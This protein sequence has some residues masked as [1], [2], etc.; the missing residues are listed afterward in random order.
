MSIAPR[1]SGD[2]ATADHIHR[3]P[4]KMA[5]GLAEHFFDEIAGKHLGHFE[6]D[7]LRRF[8]DPFCGSGTTLLVARSRGLPASGSDILDSSVLL[9]RAK[10]NRLGTSSLNALEAE[11]KAEP[12]TGAALPVR[13]WPTAGKWFAPR[14]LRAIQDIDRRVERRRSRRYFPHLW[15]ALSQTCWDVSSADRNVM[16]P[17]H[18]NESRGS[19][20]FAPKTVLAK[21]RARLRRVVSAQYALGR[22]NFPCDG[23][24][25]WRADATMNSG[26]PRNRSGVVLSSPPYGLGIDYVRAASLQSTALGVADAVEWSRRRVVGRLSHLGNVENLLEQYSAERW[27]QTL[28]M[29]GSDRLEGLIRYFDDLGRFFSMCEAHVASEGI[30]GVVLGDPEMSGIRIPLVKVADDLARAS[31]LVRE[32]EPLTDRIRRR[33]QTAQRR[34]SRSPIS[35][36]TLLTYTLN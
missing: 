20:Q 18:S 13:P 19:R 33:F 12:L 4:A 22:L 27:Y 10:V 16:V 15:V 26:W 32:R 2:L 34:S 35:S 17:T 7:D 8:H 23:A 14:V 29:R 28:S 6:G 21:Y 11:L 25:V 30:V 31:G 3:F 9:A 5:L 1:W 36:E 24:N